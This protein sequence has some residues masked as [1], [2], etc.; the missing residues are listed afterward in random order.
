M[1]ES[2]LNFWLI[3]LVMML[4]PHCYSVYNIECVLFLYTYMCAQRSIYY[5]TYWSD[6]DSKKRAQRYFIHIEVKLYTIHTYY[7]YK[8]TYNRVVYNI[9]LCRYVLIRV[10]L[11]YASWN[12]NLVDLLYQRI[13]HGIFVESIVAVHLY[14]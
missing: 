7:I 12:K 14:V 10:Y 5:K 4:P 3:L 8:T 11:Y 13:S 2:E 6:A 1:A 9:M